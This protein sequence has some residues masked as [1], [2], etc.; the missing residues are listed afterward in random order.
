MENQSEMDQLTLEQLQNEILKFLPLMSV[1]DPNKRGEAEKKLL[2][3]SHNQHFFIACTNLYTQNP[4]TNLMVGI[5]LRNSLGATDVTLRRRIEEKYLNSNNKTEIKKKLLEMKDEISMDCIARIGTLELVRNEWPTFFVD[6]QT[7][8]LILAINYLKTYNFNFNNYLEMILNRMKDNPDGLIQIVEIFKEKLP[9]KILNDLLQLCYNKTDINGL[10][11][12]FE[13]CFA[14]IENKTAIINF[15]ATNVDIDDYEPVEFFRVLDSYNFAFD[16]SCLFNYLNSEDQKANASAED[17]LCEVMPKIFNGATPDH[18]AL[19]EQTVASV[20]MFLSQQRCD[21]N[22]HNL[23]S[24]SINLDDINLLPKR[25]FARL[26]GCCPQM[27]RAEFYDIFIKTQAFWTLKK[28][29]LFNFEEVSLYLPGIVKS[30]ITAI[31]TSLDEEASELVQILAQQVDGNVYENE[32]TFCFIELLNSLVLATERVPYTEYGKRSAIFSALIE[33]VKSCSGMHS[34]GLEKLLYYLIS[35]VKESLRIVDKLNTNEFL[36][37][38][39]ILTWFIS[40]IEEILRKHQQIGNQEYLESVYD[41]YYDILNLKRISSLVGDVYISLSSLII[42]NSFFLGKMD[43][44]VHFITRDIKY[45]PGQDTYTFKAAHLLIGDVS[46]VLSKGI[47]KYSYLAQL[48]ITNLGSDSVQRSLKPVLLSILG[49]LIFALGT[50][51]IYKDITC[52]M[53]QEIINLDRNMDILFIDELRRCAIILLDTLLITFEQEIPNNLLLQFLTKV[54][55]EDDRLHC[56]SQLL[57]LAADYLSVYYYENNNENN[58]SK[59]NIF[60]HLVQIGRK[61]QPEKANNLA[62]LLG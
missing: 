32:L 10:K 25:S 52:E 56:T 7:R 53:L 14:Q 20:E 17:L 26:I 29:A 46:Q 59:N 47:L 18:I 22:N 50:S 9:N 24:S 61:V 2:Q 57:D 23:S 60:T 4:R 19:Q 45:K 28:L 55:N 35:K 62:A 41:I 13:N 30:I 37:L 58:K 16:P 15:V 3:M 31:E 36:I 33:L 38:E 44:I 6:C 39:D 43:E 11:K 42:G 51:F 12:L 5:L 8:S 27:N 40:L 48:V 34:S 54:L 1:P 21:Q 49:D